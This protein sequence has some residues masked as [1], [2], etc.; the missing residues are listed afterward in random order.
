MNK[1]ISKQL[2]VVARNLV[3]MT[4]EEYEK[5]EQWKLS[6][7]EKLNKDF[8]EVEVYCVTGTISPV[9]IKYEDFEYDIED[10]QNLVRRNERKFSEM[11]KALQHAKSIQIKAEKIAQKDKIS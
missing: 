11:K 1:N 7:Y 2:L 8:G 4:L 5:L 9:R 10:F 6:E 3:S